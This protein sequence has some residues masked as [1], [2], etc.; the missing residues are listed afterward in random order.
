MSDWVTKVYN[1]EYV[2]T[3]LLCVC[4]HACVRVCV[5]MPT[6][7][8]S[9]FILLYMC[10]YACTQS[11]PTVSLPLPPTRQSPACTQ[12]VDKYVVQDTEEARVNTA[13]YPR[14]L[15]VIEGPLMKV[16]LPEWT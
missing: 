3:Q 2:H 8:Y 7:L 13:A 4:V 12:G 6:L 11:F 10:M 16:G 9:Q 14:P 5:C 1:S 15:N